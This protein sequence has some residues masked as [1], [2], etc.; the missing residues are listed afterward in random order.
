MQG[1]SNIR[2]S[3]K[4]IHYIKKL[5][6]KNHMTILLDAEKAFDKNPT[7]I[8][9]K[10]LGKIWNSRPIPKHNKGNIQQTSGQHQSKWRET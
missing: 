5:K 6:D 4:V 3:I 9:D 7:P 2:K 1:W 10:S 8:H